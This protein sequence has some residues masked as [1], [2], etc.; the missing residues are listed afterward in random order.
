MADG[1]GL[2]PETP[3]DFPAVAFGLSDPGRLVRVCGTRGRCIS[4][5]TRF[6]GWG[7]REDRPPPPWKK[8]FL[9]TTSPPRSFILSHLWKIWWNR[10]HPENVVMMMPQPSA[11]YKCP[12]TWM[13]IQYSETWRG[14]V[15]Y[16]KCE[17]SAK[18]LATFSEALD[19]EFFFSIGNFF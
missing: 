8:I 7:S 4:F 1:D 5:I 18:V 10:T 14:A 9:F 19:T 12:L 17:K 2:V 13:L 16:F 15:T 3:W 11:Y 6:L